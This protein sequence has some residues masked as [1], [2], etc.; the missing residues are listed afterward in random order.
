MFN[1]TFINFTNDKIKFKENVVHRF[2]GVVQYCTNLFENRFYT[3][4]SFYYINH[5]LII[6]QCDFYF[7]CVQHIFDNFKDN[8]I[9][10]RF[11]IYN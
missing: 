9:V 4:I 1:L 11:T 10:C 6:T 2:P 3:W 8:S 7:Y 5:W